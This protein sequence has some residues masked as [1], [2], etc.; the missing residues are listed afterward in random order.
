MQTILITT[1]F[2]DSSLNAARY[3]TAL[4]QKIG[5]DRI[6]LYY[7]Y[8]N[9]SFNT[10]SP[11][12]E[13]EISLT[14]EGSL[15]ALEIIEREIKEVLDNDTNVSIDLITNELPLIV[16]VE[17]LV[18]RWQ[19]DLVVA[20]TTGKSGLEKFMMGSNTI[21]LASACPA[22]L[23]IVPKE[24]KFET[25]EKIVFA[26]DL[27]KISTSTPVG[28][29][30]NLLETLQAKLLV[31]NVALKGKRIDP[32]TI[33]QQYKLHTLLDELDPEYHYTE[34]DDIADEIEDF[35][36]DHDAGLIITIP[37]SYGFFEALFRRSV[38]KRL[39]NDLDTPLLLLKE[40]EA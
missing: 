5:V 34:S 17:Q 16:G 2:S 24:A 40:K 14:H 22:P 38:S 19:V 11:V 21:S 27:K 32:D 18:E 28:V 39:I 10:D 9:T 20:G 6:M 29:I 33:P 15:L 3:A 1:D 25:I 7:S 13:P 37:I 8:D 23:L 12:A 30:K 35:A 31:L 26:C 36:E 4:A